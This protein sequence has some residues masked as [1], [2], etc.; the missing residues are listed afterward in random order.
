MLRLDRR[1]DRRYR[2]RRC[3]TQEM[4]QVVGYVPGVVYR[5]VARLESALI[6]SALVRGVA[7][8][9]WQ[10]FFFETEAQSI[11]QEEQ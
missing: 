1:C 8:S 6:I 11:S 2:L 9:S 5:S 3:R 4:T 7:H 10:A